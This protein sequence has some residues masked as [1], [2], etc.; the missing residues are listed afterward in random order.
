[1]VKKRLIFTLLYQNSSFHLSRNFRLQRVGDINWLNKNYNFSHIATAIDEL[2]IL[3]VSREGHDTDAFCESIQQVTQGCFMPLALGGGIT[4]PEQVALMMASGADKIVLN[5]AL[6]KDPGLV[7]ELVSH[8]GSQCVVAAVDYRLQD[9][10]FVVYV[11]CGRAQ[12]AQPL[13]I[14]LEQLAELHVGEIYLN[15]MD[16]DG[17]GQGYCLE[18]L[19]Q[20]GGIAHIPVIMAGGAGNHNHLL[21]GIQHPG[22][23]A[24][25]TANLFNFV[26]NG[27]PSARRQLLDTGVELAQW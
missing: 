17:T 23:D 6:T 8:Y 7:R 16:K 5:T 19:D 4:H 27:L 22:I 9:G 20:I 21:T 15:S 25:A 11:D 2:I 12:V 14:Y 26:G 3:D 10:E 24:V 1:M 13:A 18:V